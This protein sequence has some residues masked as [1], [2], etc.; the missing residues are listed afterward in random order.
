LNKTTI[1]MDTILYLSLY[2]FVDS[3]HLPNLT[4]KRYIWY[5]RRSILTVP[6]VIRIP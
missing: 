5:K 2:Y 6:W 4:I 3:V 1:P